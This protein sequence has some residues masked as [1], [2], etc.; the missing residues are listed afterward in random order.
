M[1][2]RQSTYAAGDATLGAAV[3]A[4]V[5]TLT[6]SS[7]AVSLIDALRHRF[8]V[9]TRPAEYDRGLEEEMRFHLSLDTAR[10]HDPDPAA[11]RRRFGNVTYL[12]EE[13]RHMAG[14]ASLD[15]LTHDAR[16]MVRSLRRSPGFATVAILT[17]AL[18]IGVTT[19]VLSVVDHVLVHA[20]PL[21]NPDRVV[22]LLERDSRASGAGNAFR[23]PSPPTAEDWRRDPATQRAFSDIAFVRGEGTSFQLGEINEHIAVGYVGPEFFRV[24]SAAPTLGRALTDDDH[25]DGAP[26]AA[27]LQNWFWR[28]KLGSDPN[29]V[30]KIADVG[31]TPYTIVGVM[32]PGVNF[33][34]FATAW[35]SVSQMKNKEIL[36]KRSLHVDERTIARLR[37][38]VDSAQAVALMKTVAANLGA[39]YP[40][41]QAGWE[42][43]IFP[44]RDEVIGNIKPM[45]WTIAAAAAAVLLLACTN[46]ANLLLARV[47]ARSREL[48]VRSA[49]GASRWRLLRQLLTESLVLAL[50]GGVLGTAVAAVAVRATRMW[51]II[52]RAEEIAVDGRVLF[53]AAAI[54]AL[55]A[56]LCGVWPAVRATRDKAG[57][58]LRA[59]SLGSVG[60]RG[61]SRGR[62]ALV[63]VQ[64]ALALAMLVVAGLLLQSFRR[65]AAVDVGFDP[66]GLVSVQLNPPA[67]YATAEDAA[68]LYERLMNAA[69]EVPG[70]V[71]V[72]F[73]NHVP[74]HGAAAVTGVQI[75]G[76]ASDTAAHQVF[77][78]TVSAGYLD[79]MKMTMAA[80]RWFDANDMRSPG[81]GFI[82]N[83]TMAK[84]FWGSVNAVGKRFTIHRASQARPNFGEPMTGVVLGVV[85][86]VHQTAQDAAPDAEVYVPYT[87]EPWPWGNLVVRAR[88]GARAIP[89]LRSAIEAVDPRLVEKGSAGNERFG[90]FDEAIESS[91]GPRKIAISFIGGFA[92]CALILAAIGMYGVVSYGVTQRTRE[93]GLR[94]ALGATDGMI[95]QLLL[96]ESALLTGMGIVLGIAGA[97]FGARFITDMLFQTGVADLSVYFPTALLL[98]AIAL[99]ATYIPARRATRLDPTIAMRGE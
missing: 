82:V 21:R 10:T 55:T 87:L 58:A 94:K 53:V 52:P 84:R 12:K 26:P 33:P 27:V 93:L 50:A 59:S 56:L 73:I 96:R 61:E 60:I 39:A 2:G 41:E 37:P 71:N 47:A 45:L 91:L 67:S 11:A 3:R 43:A 19:A 79:T 24:L 16:Y 88:D 97:W 42:P 62:R 9:W 98:A 25:R 54:C 72:G 20:I 30:G 38:G 31:G 85:N 64:F 14:L 69:R 36:T 66:H 68:A 29:I 1:I 18:G 75:E 22:Y 57:E 92:A 35:V 99:V 89:L 28:R 78:R 34:N 40:K 51:T 76:G 5:R 63:T 83:A 65:A 49:I 46:V 23:T 17:L 8:R 13:T 70:V 90:T 81:A 7:S 6:V 74:F 15:A 77:Y 48:A 4:A 32:A 80:G 95:A 86:D 44:V